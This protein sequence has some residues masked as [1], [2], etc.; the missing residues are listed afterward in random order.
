[1]VNILELNN[2]V[3]HFIV[4]HKLTTIKLHKVMKPNKPKEGL[5]NKNMK[6]TSF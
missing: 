3:V 2:F 1:M 6:E 5:N 4:K